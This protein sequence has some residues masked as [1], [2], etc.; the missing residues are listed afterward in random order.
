MKRNIKIVSKILLWI[1][2]LVHIY[3]MYVAPIIRSNF[4]WNYVQDVW[5]R[6]QAIIVGG[7]AS[8]T[9]YIIYEITKINEKERRKNS[10]K[11]ARSNLSSSLSYLNSYIKK[12]SN[13]LYQIWGDVITEENYTRKSYSNIPGVPKEHVN[14]F[15]KC[16]E[17]TD[18][19]NLESH[20]INIMTKLQIQY[21]RISEY[22]TEDSSMMVTPGNV[23]YE[24][25]N[26]LEL[27]TLINKTY[28][29][30]RKEEETVNPEI[31]RDEIY[32]SFLNMGWNL[33]HFSYDEVA[34][35]K[36]IINLNYK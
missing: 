1:I 15:N 16:I 22:D 4:D 13:I 20:L 6:W 14:T 31:V 29:Y 27:S 11:A 25:L 12:C 8:I 21:S 23:L 32:N 30:A 35:I 2:I 24:I 34:N 5:D 10:L 17:Y 33:S 36:R 9:S 26:L 18:D 3:S 7:L 28:N 19:E